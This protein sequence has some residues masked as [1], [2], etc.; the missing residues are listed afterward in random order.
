MFCYFLLEM[1]APRKL[2]TQQKQGLRE[3]ANLRMLSERFRS[4]LFGEE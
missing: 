4:E 1:G 2:K 3:V